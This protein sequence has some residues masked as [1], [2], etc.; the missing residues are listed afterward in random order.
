MLFQKQLK[1]LITIVE[2]QLQYTGYFKTSLIQGSQ[3][4]K[5]VVEDAS[6]RRISVFSTPS[7]HHYP[8]STILETRKRLMNKK[9]WGEDE[10]EDEEML[11]CDKLKK[12]WLISLLF[13]TSF[14]FRAKLSLELLKRQVYHVPCQHRHKS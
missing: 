1:I 5:I 3:S 7:I 11:V 4:C 13:L 8:F 12:T 14:L 2:N 6:T 10:L 9:C